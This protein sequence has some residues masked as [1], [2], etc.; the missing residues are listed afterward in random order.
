[1]TPIVEIHRLSFAY[2]GSSLVLRDISLRFEA[3]ETVAI[4]GPNGAG[5]S[6]LLLHLIGLLPEEFTPDA[7]KVIIDGRSVERAE[8]TEIR[9]RVGFVFQDPDD[10][11]FCPTLLEDVM[12]GPL[13]LPLTPEQAR[14]RSLAAIESVGLAGL[15]DRSPRELSVG[16][17]K[18]ACLAGVLACQPRLLVLDEP[19]SHLDPRGRREFIQLLAALDI[20]KVIATH[21]LDL[22]IEIAPRVIVLDGGR[23]VADGPAVEILSN[24][25]L[26]D[27][28]GLE[29]PHALVNETVSQPPEPPSAALS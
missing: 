25:R 8:L 9:R 20:G 13:H 26:M 27:R 19:T 7:G 12:F 28:H 1:M 14:V 17:R 11:L 29:V 5:K 22:V 6:T 3:G 15:E 4:V 23:V 21:D 2:S 10:Q 24:G 18:R 16:Q